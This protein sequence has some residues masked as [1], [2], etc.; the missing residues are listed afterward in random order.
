MLGRVR[1]GWNPPKV[2]SG[3]WFGSGTKER[4][5]SFPQFAKS[6]ST[7]AQPVFSPAVGSTCPWKWSGI[8]C[9]ACSAETRI[10]K[11]SF[12]VLRWC[13][14]KETPGIVPG[15]ADDCWWK[16][17]YWDPSLILDSNKGGERKHLNSISLHLASAAEANSAW[18]L[19]PAVAQSTSLIFLERATSSSV[20]Y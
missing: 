3:F 18:L 19:N 9:G 7:Y 4:I 1:S 6:V 8:N 5:I 13:I 12:C 17:P 16:S 10:I 11:T 20:L 15:D 14:P 2:S